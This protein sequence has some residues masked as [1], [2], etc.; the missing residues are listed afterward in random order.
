MFFTKLAVLL[1]TS[2]AACTN[3]LLAAGLLVF[4][5]AAL[6]ALQRADVCLATAVAA[7]RTYQQKEDSILSVQ[8]DG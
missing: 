7:P 6:H 3:C 2:L 5:D 8:V 1:A 4:A